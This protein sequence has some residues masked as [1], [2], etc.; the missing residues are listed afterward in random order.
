[1]YLLGYSL[2]G[3]FSGYKSGHASNN[4]LLRV[5]QSDRDAWEL[6]TYDDESQ[7][8][9]SYSQLQLAQESA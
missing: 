7:V 1:M 3:E 8:P 2:I 6:V 4:A 5:L 9:S